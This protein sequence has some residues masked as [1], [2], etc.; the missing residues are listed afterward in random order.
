VIEA[1][2]LTIFENG[3]GE[4]RCQKR[5]SLDNRVYADIVNAAFTGAKLYQRPV[6]EIVG[7]SCR[8]L[9]ILVASRFSVSPLIK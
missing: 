2:N 9:L 8:H 4:G 1:F 5:R 7:A 3:Y 6:D